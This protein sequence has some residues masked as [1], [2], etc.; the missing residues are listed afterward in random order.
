[1]VK[2][3]KP[4][5]EIAERTTSYQQ[6]KFAKLYHE[7]TQKPLEKNGTGKTHTTHDPNLFTPLSYQW[8]ENFNGQEVVQLD[9][10]RKEWCQ[11]HDF[12]LA[13]NDWNEITH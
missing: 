8:W 5:S 4:W 1:M 6:L 3:K 7:L 2:D 12:F 11:F 13:R 10:F 9:D